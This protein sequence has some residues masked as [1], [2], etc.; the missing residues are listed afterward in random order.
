[1]TIK[2]ALD[3]A[4]QALSNVERPVLEAEML[5]THHLQKSRIFLHL[6]QDLRI[7]KEANFMQL[8]RKRQNNYPLE[9]LTGQVSFYDKTFHIEEGVLIPRPETELLIEKS[10]DLIAKHN[11][12]NIAEIGTGSG[13]ISIILALKYPQ[14]NFFATDINLKAIELAHKNAKAF[15][16]QN[17]ELQHCEFLNQCPSQIDFL[18]SNPPYIADDYELPKN[19]QFEPKNALFA[20]VQGDEVLK[21]IINLS[22][23]KQIAT[24]ALE[25]GYNQRPALSQYL[26]QNNINKFNFYKDLSDYDRV[27]VYDTN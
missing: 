12:K 11:I 14:L 26:Q 27:L 13:I 21:Q 22:I 16:V 7:E 5:L 2:S 3:F 4:K 6:N 18:I 15:Q 17:I 20:G 24:V 9:Y 10:S 25:I 8:L 1:M 23:D 19:V